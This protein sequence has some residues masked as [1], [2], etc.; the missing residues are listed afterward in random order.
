MRW[1]GKCKLKLFREQRGFTLIEILIAVGILG[2]MGVAFITALDTS[3]RTARILDEQVVAAN[4]AYG[5]LEAINFSPYAA[6]YPNVGENITVPFQYSVTIETECSSDGV[7]FSACSE[8]ET[9]QKI[10]I[11]VSREGRPVYSGCTYRCKR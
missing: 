3:S 5:H 9:L 8:N 2:F 10:M 4:L 7:I 6:T 1:L 11:I